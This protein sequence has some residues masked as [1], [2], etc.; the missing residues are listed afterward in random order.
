MYLK[1]HG[2]RLFSLSVFMTFQRAIDLLLD[3]AI[4]VAFSHHLRNLNLRLYFVFLAAQ[5]FYCGSSLPVLLYQSS[6][7]VSLLFIWDALES[8]RICTLETAVKYTASGIAQGDVHLTI[9]GVPHPRNQSSVLSCWSW[10][11]GYMLIG[12]YHT[13]FSSSQTSA[14]LSKNS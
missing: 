10:L 2:Y 7:S 5:H 1:W 11:Y 14:P 9:R 8:V 12:Y 6:A 4:D 3:S 13:R